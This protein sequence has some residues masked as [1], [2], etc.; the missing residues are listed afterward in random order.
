MVFDVVALGHDWDRLLQH[1][2]QLGDLITEMANQYSWLNMDRNGKRL[3]AH[4]D[5][6]AAELYWIRAIVFVYLAFAHTSLLFLAAAI[7]IKLTAH[8]L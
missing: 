7:L 6:F 8:E 1:R 5:Q 3:F 4:H 2:A